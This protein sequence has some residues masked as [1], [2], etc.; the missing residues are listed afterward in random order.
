MQIFAKT[1]VRVSVLAAIVAVGYVSTNVL[2]RT[3]RTE[4]PT[5]QVSSGVPAPESGQKKVILKSLGM[6]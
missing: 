5:A 3:A 6:T 1:W 2:F 4:G